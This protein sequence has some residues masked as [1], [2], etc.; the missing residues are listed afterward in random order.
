MQEMIETLLQYGYVI[1]FIYSFGG[2]MVGILAAG[3]L[4][5]QGKFDIHLCILLAFI[6]NTLGSTLLF[7]LGKYYKKDLMPYFKK[8]RR[9]IA[10]AILKIKQY[11]IFL[12]STQKFI[13]GLK[14]FIP[15][16]AGFAKYNFMKFC[17][18]N[19]LASL[20]WAILLGYSAFLFGTLI[21]K[22]FT[23]LGD[24]SYGAPLFL[25]F[26]LGGIWFYLNK[27]SKK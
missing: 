20:L 6:S 2:G 5:A 21:E 10:L 24:Y 15:I 11:G 7:I 1:L 9:K 8:H 25:I 22:F 17:L 13:Y 12:L 23:K 18:I 14:T 3:V 16:A 4:S 26:L 19:T 27:F